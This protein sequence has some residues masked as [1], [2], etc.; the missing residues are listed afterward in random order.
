[1][2]VK[3]AIEELRGSLK[4]QHLERI[5]VECSGQEIESLEKVYESNR[6]EH[7]FDDWWCR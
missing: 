3:I 1:M 7:S 4:F 5:S 2:E 6:G